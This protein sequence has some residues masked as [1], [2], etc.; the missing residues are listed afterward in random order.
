[1]RRTIAEVLGR[2]LLAHTVLLY[3]N[4]NPGKTDLPWILD[5]L[6]FYMDATPQF[7]IAV[8][9]GFGIAAGLQP[10]RPN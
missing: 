9:A 10:R 8:V 7:V 6:M 1:M 2:L 3:E 4:I 5:H